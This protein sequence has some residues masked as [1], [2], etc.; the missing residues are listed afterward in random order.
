[1]FQ[2][3]RRLQRHDTHASSQVDCWSAG[4]VTYILLGGYPP[5]VSP[6]MEKLFRLIKRGRVNFDNVRLFFFVNSCRDL[7]PKTEREPCCT[8]NLSSPSRAL[9]VTFSGTTPTFLETHLFSRLDFFFRVVINRRRF[10]L[11]SAIFN[12]LLPWFALVQD[13]KGVGAKR[14]STGGF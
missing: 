5:F 7:R 11:D 3:S 13:R 12:E 14:Y 9:N 8:G 1:M 10:N 4:V 2:K 6:R